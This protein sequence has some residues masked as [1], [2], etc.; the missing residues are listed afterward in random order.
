MSDKHQLTLFGVIIAIGVIFSTY[1][2]T[3]VIR[4]VRLSHQIIKVRGYAEKK[5]TSDLAVWDI[6]VKNRT[7]DIA[8][9]Y[10]VIENGKRE[11][12]NFLEQNQVESGETKIYSVSIEEKK[13]KKDYLETNEL[14]HFLMIQKITITSQN[15]E[16]ISNLSTR[17]DRLI[18]KGIEIH[19]DPPK[20]YYSK[21]NEIKS[22]LLA[23]ATRDA[24]E[25]AGMLAEG[26]GVKLGFLRAARQ[27]Q[28]SI[29]PANSTSISSSGP[30]DDVSAVNKK[31]TAVVT[32]DYSMK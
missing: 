22:D 32:V 18:K 11:I 5:V 4:D 9:G 16:K 6:M 26:S 19:S 21:V 29:R 20:Y 10:A 3:D 15:V 27:G 8:G 24:R 12:L 30:Y 14:E 7:K 28:F 2:V 1:L 13:K 31:I 17:I 23:D 25:R